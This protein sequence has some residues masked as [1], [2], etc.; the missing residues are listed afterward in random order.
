MKL[1]P[2]NLSDIFDSALG[3]ASWSDCTSAFI[4]A[5]RRS[6]R[7]IYQANFGDMYW[8]DTFRMPSIQSSDRSG[9]RTM[10]QSRSLFTW[11]LARSSDHRVVAWYVE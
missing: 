2:M 7:C 11:G 1:T 8:R 3:A 4:A 5:K 9:Y 6:L 10:S